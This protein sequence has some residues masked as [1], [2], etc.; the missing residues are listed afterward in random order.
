MPESQPSPTLIL[1]ALQ[2]A[3]L[4][5]A[6]EALGLLSRVRGQGTDDCERCRKAM[7]LIRAALGKAGDP[8]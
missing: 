6:I 8:A 1:V 5:L 4:R 2:P 7:E 3:H